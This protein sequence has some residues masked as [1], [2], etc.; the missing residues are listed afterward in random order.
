MTSGKITTTHLEKT[1]YVY[2]RQSSM[3]QVRNHRE[4]TERQYALQQTARSLG[5]SLARIKVLDGDLGKSGILG[6]LGF[7]EKSFQPC[8]WSQT[9]WGSCRTCL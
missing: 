9:P 2:L 8:V 5:W 6:S 4:S 7:R 1:A 3:G